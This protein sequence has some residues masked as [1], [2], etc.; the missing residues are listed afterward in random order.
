MKYEGLLQIMRNNYLCSEEA[1]LCL[2]N[3]HYINILEVYFIGS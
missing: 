1:I 3:K 2:L